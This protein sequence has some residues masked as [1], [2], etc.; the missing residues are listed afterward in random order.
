[1]GGES[2]TWNRFGSL[3][4]WLGIEVSGVAGTMGAAVIALGA[5]GGDLDGL[6]AIRA[7]VMGQEAPAYSLL[8][9]HF[10]PW[11][12]KAE[13]TWQGAVF[14]SGGT[15]RLPWGPCSPCVPLLLP[16]GD[17]LPEV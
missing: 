8:W 1:M 10:P 12:L 15:P 17:S 14:S 6:S 7:E 16:L 3:G 11:I 4:I 9:V 2:E 13:D 5:S